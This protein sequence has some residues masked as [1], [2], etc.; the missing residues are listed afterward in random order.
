MQL[1]AVCLLLAAKLNQPLSPSFYQ[2]IML[3]DEQYR[4]DPNCKPRMIALE[5]NI[6]SQLQFDLQ[7]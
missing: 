6:V 7:I 2:M 5:H 1:G 3:L 4:R